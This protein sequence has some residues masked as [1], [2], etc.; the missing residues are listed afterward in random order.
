MDNRTTNED[1]EAAAAI[2]HPLLNK[3][4]TAEI[5]NNLPDETA[6][7]VADLIEAA[8]KRRKPAENAI[9]YFESGWCKAEVRWDLLPLI[10][11]AMSEALLKERGV[12]SDLQKQPEQ[13]ED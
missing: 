1:M 6:Q 3:W 9:Y 7:A 4:L 12:N 5:I 10:R 2:Y 11:E 8:V 13:P